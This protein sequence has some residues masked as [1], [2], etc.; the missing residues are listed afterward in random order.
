M[1]D[2]CPELLGLGLALD[3]PGAE[4]LPEPEGMG[5]APVEELLGLADDL[6][7]TEPGAELFEL[8]GMGIGTMPVPCEDEAP[9][10]GPVSEDASELVPSVLDEWPW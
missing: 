7:L 3:D 4:W 6:M 1:L 5:A 8:V 2:A 10:D 9:G